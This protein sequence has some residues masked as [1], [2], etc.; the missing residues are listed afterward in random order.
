MQYK[1]H[2][3]TLEGKARLE[4]ELENIKAVERPQLAQSLKE[5]HEGGDITDNAAFES[6]KERMAWLGERMAEIESLLR[7]AEIISDNGHNKGIVEVG[8]VVRVTKED[9]EVTEYTVVDSL[10]AAPHDRRISDA[11][12]IGSALLGCKIGDVVTVKVPNRT[13]QLTI[14]EVH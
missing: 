9:G 14:T 7:E 8:S 13:L 6:M 2:K 12:P 1:H 10:E 11:S 4:A 3:L 5:W